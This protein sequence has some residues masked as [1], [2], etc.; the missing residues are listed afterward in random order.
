M[1]LVQTWKRPGLRTSFSNVWSYGDRKIGPSDFRLRNGPGLPLKLLWRSR[2]DSLAIPAPSIRSLSLFPIPSNAL[3]ELLLHSFG[4][5]L[6]CRRPPTGN[7]AESRIPFLQRPCKRVATASLTN[8]GNS[9]LEDIFPTL[10]SRK[11]SAS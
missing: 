8:H 11:W 5:I 7:C 10:Q 1:R 9:I 2:S 6:L 3:A 4:T